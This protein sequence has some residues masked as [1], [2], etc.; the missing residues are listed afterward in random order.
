MN[1]TDSQMIDLI[2]RSGLLPLK[3]YLAKNPDIAAAGV[4]PVEHWYF[5]ARTERRNPNFLFSTAY[6][7]KNNKDVA[8]SDL[9]PLAHYILFGE[10]EGRR[11]SQFFDSAWYRTQFQKH[12]DF[13]KYPTALSHYLDNVT[14][15]DLSPNPYF[16]TKYY[17]D[18]YPDV[19]AA[20][21][22]PFEHFIY[23]GVFEGRNP[24]SSFET[25][26]YSQRHG[27]PIEQN[28][29]EHFLEIGL[30]QKLVT[31][32]AEDKSV[33]AEIQKWTSPG[34][35]FK[36][37]TAQR[38]PGKQQSQV[39]AFAFYL[40]QFHPIA[41]N[42][43]AW[44]AGFTEWRNIARGVPRFEGH[45]QP[46]VPRDLGF[47]DLRS[48]DVIA[49]Q[50]A[51]ATRA[52]LKGFAFYY[53]TFDGERV[54]DL[55][56]DVFM[57]LEHD[58]NF[59]LIW[60]NENW[61]RTWDGMD[62]EVIKG[63][64]FDWKVIPTIAKD[65]A[66]HM[67]DPRY[68][69]IDGRPL[70]VVYRPGIIP[71]AKQYLSRL[72]EL[73]AEEIGVV[74]LFFMAQGF[75][76]EDPAKFGLNGAIE[77]PPHKIGQ[78]LET[79][80][81]RLNS[82]DH[83]YRG[84][85]F[86][87]DDFVNASIEVKA[88]SYPLIRTVFPSWDNEARRPGTG[89]TV[90][91]ST[92]QKYRRW[93]AHAVKYAR[94]NPIAGQSIVAINAWNEWCEGAYLEPDVHYGSAYLDATS[95]VICKEASVPSGESIL[96][97]GHDAYRHG[98]QL[99]LLNIA[100]QLK[101][102]GHRVAILVLQGGPLEPEYQRVADFFAVVE[103]S[104]GVHRILS[105]PAL[106]GYRLAITN[107]V[108][109]GAI[110][111]ELKEHSFRVVSLVHE[112]GTIIEERGLQPRCD[113][114]GKYSDKIVF[115]SD[116]VLQSF[117]GKQSIPAGK[118]RIM[119]QGIYNPPLM[120]MTAGKTK[121]H[122]VICN[123][124]F[125]DLR[126]GYDLFVAI[127]DYFHTHNLPGRFVWVGD[128]EKGLDTWLKSG[129]DNFVRIPFTDDIYPILEHADVFLLTSR[130]DPF[131]TVALEAWAVG[132]PVVCFEGTGGIP[133]LV[134]QNPA[135]GS[136]APAFSIQD[137]A[138]EVC[139][140]IS[141]NN[142]AHRQARSDLALS[143][144]SFSRYISSL[145]GELGVRKGSVAAVIPNY[146]Y[147]DYMAGRVESVVNQTYKP[148]QVFLLD[149]ASKDGSQQVIGEIARQYRPYVTTRFN[150]TNTGSPFAQWEAGAKLCSS[151]Y[152]WIAEADDL[153][154]PEFL[155]QSIAFMEDH[156]C[157]VCF[158][159][160]V[161]VDS[162]GGVLAKSYD[163]YFK[164]VDQ[165]AFQKSFVMEGPEFLQR[166]I[167]CKN[168]IL[169]VSAV[170]WKREVLL[171]ALAS[172]RKDLAQYRVAGDWRIY[173]HICMQG[174]RMG[175][176]ARSL[177]THRRHPESATHAQARTDQLQE[178]AQVHSEI[179]RAF[180]GKSDFIKRRQDAYVAELAAQ[181]GLAGN[182]SASRTLKSG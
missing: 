154:D 49:E 163:Y 173:A 64:K 16:S 11:P 109:T 55:P 34:A 76:D 147:R 12:L 58:L 67:A 96:L 144:F 107:T 139:E 182:K 79:I 95:R 26:F 172:L 130:E 97:C 166:M 72:C 69:C 77:F 115:A 27:V 60:A 164:T 51:M 78:G 2:R 151:K 126:K 168:V 50:V 142:A 165:T 37:L 146:N 129:G 90:H 47:Y 143:E 9:N 92:P 23:S 70:F 113:A 170:V 93:L 117:P 57:E 73:I 141:A 62:R 104:E 123:M 101:L 10:G 105:D 44:G 30:P 18:K 153:T 131:P 118:I 20:K 127:A 111:H 174:A 85:V 4:D 63:Q 128:A 180:G 40:P 135:L 24:S 43:T 17:L 61:T 162:K 74:P 125:A 28:A 6:Y 100:T 159:D 175:Y 169:N 36:E 52:G 80:N 83:S 8:E 112:M 48:P 177:N 157:D 38:G 22:G 35:D 119:P 124:G 81:G 88:P 29:F 65:I 66:R 110:V 54:L 84:N 152:V 32:P 45:Y 108:V 82:Y 21:I 71:D 134:L 89:M 99:L 106:Q 98:A 116:R 138:K 137:A 75:G 5:H 121:K 155:E 120:P 7:L 19:G 14:S 178:V 114:I 59:F 15:R 171:E 87:Y 91:G 103:R 160:S 181:F 148:D 1:F 136:V 122:P 132:V 46:R 102:L 94:Q 161:Q 156:D 42:D 150:T 56:I 39:D 167:S 3:W 68:Y 13:K 140:Q 41:L 176:I 158:T 31:H 53:Y 179:R 149:D 133:D 145:L 25:K 86:S 33:F